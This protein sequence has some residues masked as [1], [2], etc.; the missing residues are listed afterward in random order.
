M[1]SKQQRKD[2]L[3]RILR[4]RWKGHKNQTEAEYKIKA[5]I[6][7]RAWQKKNK[8]KVCANSKKYTNG[9]PGVNRRA[10]LRCGK[11][12]SRKVSEKYCRYLFS[13]HASVVRANEWPQ[14]LVDTKRQLIKLRRMLHES[15]TS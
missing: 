5:V 6:R 12:H 7:S 10:S 11:R 1:W 8:D 2:H 13:A 14:E 3:I 15:R 9:H 4:I